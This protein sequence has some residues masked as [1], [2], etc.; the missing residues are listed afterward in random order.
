[1]TNEFNSRKLTIWRAIKEFGW[2]PMVLVGIGGF[3]ILS[4]LE[5]GVFRQP[6]EL[7]EIF[8]WPLDGYDRVNRLLGAIVEPLAQ[9]VIDVVNKNFDLS[10]ALDPVWRPTFMLGMVFVVACVR[11]VLRTRE[12]KLN[13][14]LAPFFLGYV[15]LFALGVGLVPQ[16]ESWLTTGFRA[17]QTAGALFAL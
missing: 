7:V 5:K 3:S 11:V 16:E 1:M 8:R 13:R 6:L 17:T 14:I 4:I 9:P 2:F 12:R 10:L 15:L